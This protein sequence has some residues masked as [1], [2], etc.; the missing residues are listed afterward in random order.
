MEW[1]IDSS[2]NGFTIEQMKQQY[3]LAE[4]ALSGIAL[5]DYGSQSTSQLIKDFEQLQKQLVQMLK[6][7]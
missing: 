2:V 1:N 4:G 6:F 7:H 5:H 3:D